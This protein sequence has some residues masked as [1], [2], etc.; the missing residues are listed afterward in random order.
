MPSSGAK[1]RLKAM[2]EPCTLSWRREV[3][4][5]VVVVVK[6]ALRTASWEVEDEEEE[7]ERV[8]GRAGERRQP[9]WGSERWLVGKLD[10]GDAFWSIMYFAKSG[11]INICRQLIVNS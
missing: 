3:G 1:T 2:G 11:L 4:F 10:T 6:S 8:A 5:E 7:E 9:D